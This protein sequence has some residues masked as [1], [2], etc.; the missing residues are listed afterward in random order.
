MKE[1][2][3]FLRDLAKNN[4]KTWFDANKSRYKEAQAIFNDFAEKLIVGIGEFDPSVRNLTV[5]DC[6][7]RIYRDIRFSKD[8]TPYKNHMGAFVAP[9]G[10]KSC[11]S[12]YYFHIEPQ[13]SHYLGGNM[14]CAGAYMLDPK[15]LKSVREE[16]VVNGANFDKDIKS[17]KSLNFESDMMKKVPAGYDPNYEYAEYLKCRNFLMSK[18]VDDSFIL[19]DNLLDNVLETFKETVDFNNM[20]NMA[21]DYSLEM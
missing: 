10:K 6:T 7:Y 12:G 20:L 21:I 1:V 17:V 19:S 14:L 4:N 13:D 11:H 18:Y 15:A 5:K 3:S 8:K 2:V 9:G 16:I